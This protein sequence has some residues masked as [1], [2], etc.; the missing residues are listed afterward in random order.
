MPRSGEQGEK[1]ELTRDPGPTAIIIP[2]MGKAS[3]GEK[4]LKERSKWNK[5]PLFLSFAAQCQ[6]ASL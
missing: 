5:H 6:H 4:F 2:T 3:Q 1:A